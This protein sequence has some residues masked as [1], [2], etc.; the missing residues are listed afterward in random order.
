MR[1]KRMQ[2]SSRDREVLVVATIGVNASFVFPHLL[3]VVFTV[4]PKNM[5]TQCH[6]SPKK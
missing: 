3:P 5:R 2:V 1:A 6:N 4:E